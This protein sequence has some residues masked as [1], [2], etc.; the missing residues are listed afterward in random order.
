M[1]TILPEVV[2][3]IPVIHIFEANKQEAALPTIF[4][5]HGFTSVKERNLHYGYLLA[6][7]GFRVVMPEALL[8]GERRPS[9]VSD[10]KLNLAFWD[11]VLRSIREVDLLRKIYVGRG[12]VDEERIGVAGT[13]MGAITMLGALTQYDWIKAGVS[14]MGNPFY[15]EFALALIDQVKKL[16]LTGDIDDSVLESKLVQLRDYDP[17]RRIDEFAGRPLLFW[18]GKKDDVVPFH[19]AYKFY[20]QLL[21]KNM[22]EPEKLEFIVDD[23]AGH[24][25]SWDGALRLVDWFE[26]YV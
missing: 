6:Q 23:E 15:E 5:L 7:K 10:T 2:E 14:L 18:H 19:F 3:D 26:K 11:I 20:E 1:I 25:V 12:L 13:S 24:M 21:A 9:G 4:F 22:Y 16:G 8:H 17:S